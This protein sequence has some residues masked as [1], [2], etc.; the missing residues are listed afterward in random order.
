MGRRSGGGGR[1]GRSGGGG[2]G[3][4]R[5]GLSGANAQI[6]DTVQEDNIIGRVV[7]R[8]DVGRI[9]VL[10]LENGLFVSQRFSSVIAQGRA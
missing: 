5:I 2:G 6:G 8:G 10:R 1:G 7:S 9:P 4:N 3:G